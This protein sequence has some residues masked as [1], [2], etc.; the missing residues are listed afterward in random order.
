[1]A[2]EWMKAHKKTYTSQNGIYELIIEPT[3]TPKN[4]HKEIEKRNK[5]PK[6]YENSPLKDSII[7]CHA[8]LYKKI[9]RWGRSELMWEKDLVNPIAPHNALI[10]NN[11]KYVITFDDWYKLG[12]GENVMVVYGDEG[13]MIKRYK[14]HEITTLPQN[15][16]SISVTSIWWYL[17]HEAYSEDPD[18]VKVLVV[19]KDSKI[20]NRI[21]NLSTFEFEE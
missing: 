21:Y 13:D 5:N 3:Y 11:G 12:Y 8:K 7:P 1:M 10:T 18:K 16:L 20:E 6:K 17:G 9:G 19:D 14:L 15:Q 2:D 4:Y